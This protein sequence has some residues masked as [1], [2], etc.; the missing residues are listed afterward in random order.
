MKKSINIIDAIWYA[1]MILSG[2]WIILILAAPLKADSKAIDQSDDDI[3]IDEEREKFYKEVEEDLKI[4]D[5]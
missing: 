4:H 5:R 3:L 2:L 1:I